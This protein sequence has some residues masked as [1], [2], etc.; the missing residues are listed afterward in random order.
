MH[1]ILKIFRGNYMGT[2]KEGHVKLHRKI[3]FLAVAMLEKEV[4]T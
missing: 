1:L 2:G 4:Q 3:A